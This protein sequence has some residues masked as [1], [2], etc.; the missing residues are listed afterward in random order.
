MSDKTFNVAVVGATGA[1]GVELLT[2]RVGA[3]VVD[4]PAAPVVG[5][6]DHAGRGA[7]GSHELPL[8]HQPH[9]LAPLDRL[10]GPLPTG[11][12]VALG[13]R[14]GQ[15]LPDTRARKGLPAL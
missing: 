7:T 6:H 3:E 4:V 9:A 10:Q 13:L 14:R 15:N 5:P 8:D 1:V 2:G 11:R 12:R